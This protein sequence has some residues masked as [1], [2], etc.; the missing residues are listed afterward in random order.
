MDAVCAQNFLAMFTR[1][2]FMRLLD[3]DLSCS[4][5]TGRLRLVTHQL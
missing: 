3:L 5:D 1:I 4:S 2:D